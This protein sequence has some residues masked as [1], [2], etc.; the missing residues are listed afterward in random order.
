MIKQHLILGIIALAILCNQS[1]FAQTTIKNGGK[2]DIYVAIAYYIPDGVGSDASFYPEQCFSRG[3][4]RIPP[5][6]SRKMDI[7]VSHVKMMAID[8]KGNAQLV[9]HNGDEG[10]LKLRFFYSVGF[11]KA[12]SKNGYQTK[13]LKANTS[14][15]QEVTKLGAQQNNQYVVTLNP[16]SSSKFTKQISTFGFKNNTRLDVS[17][18]IRWGDEKSFGKWTKFYKLK[19]GKAHVFS[20]AFRKAKAQVELDHSTEDGYQ[21]KVY[22]L[23][24][25]RLTL[26]EDSS[27]R[28]IQWAKTMQYTFENKGNLVEVHK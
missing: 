27:S 21:K 12:F 6:T 1:S 8:A 18:R 11:P 7:K 19:A 20:N 16:K 24:A 9:H 5:G 17:Y 22:G 25:K 13:D 28:D 23:E 3:W 26:M 2:F 14:T 4:Y 15:F 10:S